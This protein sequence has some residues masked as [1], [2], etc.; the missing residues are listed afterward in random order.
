MQC[1]VAK[2]IIVINNPLCCNN[3]SVHD[4][5]ACL[6]TYSHT[7]AVVCLFVSMDVTQE[8]FKENFHL[9]RTALNQ[10]DFI[11]IFWGILCSVEFFEIFYN[12]PC[13]INYLFHTNGTWLKGIF[14]D[15]TQGKDETNISRE[16]IYALL[17]VFVFSWVLALHVYILLQAV[18]RQIKRR[19]AYNRYTGTRRTELY[20]P[21]IGNN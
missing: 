4:I 11:A 19:R 17:G 1:S 8:N 18:Y 21:L 14:N 20:R 16:Y 12:H 15:T 5:V 13:A 10:S 6:Y 7:F 3:S 9:F 2:S